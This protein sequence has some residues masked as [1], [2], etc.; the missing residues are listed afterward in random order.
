MNR[1]S[2]AVTLAAATAAASVAQTQAAAQAATQQVVYHVGDDGGPN[3]TTWRTALGNMRNHF[4]E[5]GDGNVDIVCVLNSTGIRMLQAAVNDP[6][7]AAEI[8]ALR[9]RGARFLVCAN[10][11]ARQNVQ[12]EQLFAVPSTDLVAAG[13][14]TLT[15]LQHDGYAYIRP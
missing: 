15:Q 13:V 2:L 8:A 9:A 7:M 6:A 4:D 14:V 11:L 3:R 5:L 1:R 12:R 10:S